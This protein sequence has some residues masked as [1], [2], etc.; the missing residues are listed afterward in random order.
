MKLALIPTNPTI[1]DLSA[2]AATIAR[3]AQAAAAQG[4]DCIVF[5]ELALTG[6]PP[7]DLLLHPGFIR[8]SIT[9]AR[10]LA[11]SLPKSSTIII[12]APW[13][14]DLDAYLAGTSRRLAN[15]LLIIRD[16]EISSTYFK[17]LLPTYD[18]FD[19]DR[20]FEPAA[21]DA[22]PAIIEIQGTKVGLSICEDLW[23]GQDV[24]F[25]ER[26]L[27]LLDPVTQ[28][29]HAGAKLII[30]P[31]ASPFRIGM[32]HRHRELLAHHARTHAIP[33]AAVNQLGGNDELIFDGSACF[34]DATGRLHA[35]NIPLS[36][37][38][39]FI[40]TENLKASANATDPACS[41]SDM[42][43]LFSALVL[44]LRDYARKIGF[45]S[46][47]LGLSGGID[48]AVVAVLAAA[49]LGPRA[50]HGVSL[51]SRFSSKGSIDDAVA[52]A[53]N[54]NIHHQTLPIEPPFQS[55][56]TTLEGSFAGKPQDVTEENLQSRI[57]GTLLM[58]LS[59]KFGHLLLTTGNKSELAVGYCTLYGDM[60]GGL[61]VISDV[62]KT[63]VYELARWINDN[64]QSLA[65]E[66][67]KV[68]PIPESSINKPPSAEL[69]E[70]QTD[71]DSLPPY[72]VLDEILKRAIE[73]RQSKE[74]IIQALAPNQT[75]KPGATSDL[76]A[77]EPTITRIFRLIQLAEFKRYQA[78]LG[79][80]VT[81]VAFGSGR[82][83]PI[84]QK[85]QG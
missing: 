5:P 70:N 24:G 81:S 33:V 74:E 58:A 17:R 56:L 15:A 2:N 10:N 63:R 59:N 32:L 35:A 51:P 7:R 36:G 44:G 22:P 82:R 66:G 55:L 21:V 68:P 57:R 84:V 62:A 19:E 65:I 69:R 16:G 53:K 41:P 6:Y 11:T 38:P 75:G 13:P 4:A 64:Y 9:T 20:Y 73:D 71:Q 30:N 45:R 29:A 49:A 37:L 25:S 1:G 8:Q 46:A 78:A 52:L 60:N 31:S 48:S 27:S 23:R 67:L 42:Q 26:Y 77:D 47:V 18:V 72:D 76:T 28:L 85:F 3:E 83:W 50:I 43:S 80:K 39:L 34:V 12:G 61:A 40:D 54:L 79:L 14:H